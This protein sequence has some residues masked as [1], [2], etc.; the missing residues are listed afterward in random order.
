[1]NKKE[2][3]QKVFENIYAMEEKRIDRKVRQIEGLFDENPLKF[4]ELSIDRA[5]ARKLKEKEQ[6]H[7]F[8]TYE[9][10]LEEEME[11]N[12]KI[13]EHL[14]SLIKKFGIKI[15]RE[16]GMPNS[17]KHIRKCD[18]DDRV[19]LA[20]KGRSFFEA[21]TAYKGMALDK[22]TSVIKHITYLIDI[23]NQLNLLASL[24]HELLAPEYIIKMC[25]GMHFIPVDWQDKL[26][27]Y[28]GQLVEM[29]QDPKQKK[30]R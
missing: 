20:Y 13:Q 12:K 26:A 28:T 18:L 11:K 15:D 8:R 5:L 9:E 17:F 10:I 24:I 6:Q 14:K 27:I 4:D 23:K 19:F 2:E 25:E 29:P 22:A 3:V 21:D 30:G 7:L 1:M 16:A